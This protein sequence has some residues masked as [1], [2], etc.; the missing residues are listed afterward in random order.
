[1]Q[2]RIQVGSWV[3]VI[4]SLAPSTHQV[5]VAA[6]LAM[7]LSLGLGLAY[8]AVTLDTLGKLLL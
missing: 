4:L 2:G 5:I 1:M 8:M 3:I 6:G 7:V